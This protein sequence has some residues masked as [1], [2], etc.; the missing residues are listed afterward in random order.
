MTYASIYLCLVSALMIWDYV[1]GTLY[2][3][4]LMI[5]SWFSFKRYQAELAREKL[6]CEKGLKPA[7]RTPPTPPTKNPPKSTK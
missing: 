4:N 1:R 2:N 3:W 5:Y 6:I 7:K